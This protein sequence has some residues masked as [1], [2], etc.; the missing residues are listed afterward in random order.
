MAQT[1]INI[2]LKDTTLS[3]RQ[4]AEG[5]AALVYGIK[6]STGNLI[7]KPTLVT[8]LDSYNAWAASNDA[9]AKALNNDPH[10][11]GIVTQFYA[12]AGSGAYL[13]LIFEDGEKGNFVTSNAASIKRQLR[14]TTEANYDNRPRIIGWCSQSNDDTTGWLPTTT[15]GTVSAIETIQN[16]MFAEGIRFVN[17][18]TATVDA[19]QATSSTNITDISTY[20]AP[21]VAF[22]PTTTLYNTTTDGSGN[23]TAY[24]PVKDVG[25]AIGILSAISVAESIGSH[26]RP[27]VAQKA[28][29]ADPE[30]VVSVTEVDPTV[31][32]ALGKGQYLFHRPYPTGIYYN[33]GA[34]CNDS[35]KALSRLE[36]V[37]LGNAVCDDA[38]EF[39]SK[40]LNTQ[41]PVES[42]GDLSKTYA[43]Q[44]ENNFYNTYCQP[45]ISQRQCSGIR[46][47]I[48]AKDDN[49]VSSRT[50]EVSIEILPSPNVD[51]VNVGV[52]YVSA[53]S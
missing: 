26:E 53:L 21:S 37:R 12:K 10:L 44:L 6:I 52:L 13:W 32:D 17:V 48:G 24:V 4:P 45:R 11:L 33:D 20:N 29:F 14:M 16:D 18:Y 8:S 5:N 15:S 19:S 38:Q 34:T 22:M 9:N 43:T 28:F 39:F 2:E 40:I 1:G 51:W 30:T 35:T 41:A 49:F 27:A 42:N 23:I 31:I 47:T 46:V 3:R 50:I 7:A 25:E 36:F